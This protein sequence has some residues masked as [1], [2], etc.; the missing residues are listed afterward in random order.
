MNFVE[1]AVLEST[2]GVSFKK[3]VKVTKTEHDLTPA[4]SF[5]GSTKSLR[6]QLLEQ[7]EKKDEEWKKA[8]NPF[9]MPTA[10]AQFFFCRTGAP[11]ALNEDEVSFY[12]EKDDER[13]A[14]ELAKKNDESL[15]KSLFEQELLAARLQTV[16][17]AEPAPEAPAP[18]SKAKAEPRPVQMVVTT[19]TR[20]KD[21]SATQAGSK[22]EKK[23]SK[24][25]DAPESK[26]SSPKRA[27][28]SDG[29]S[30]SSKAHQP[31]KTGTQNAVAPAGTGALALLGQY[32]EDES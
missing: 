21:A 19:V 25:K 7:K 31:N 22:K 20:R 30:D 12:Q 29:K 3:E 11:A 15:A 1:S 5:T 14:K 9:R 24:R 17:A 18:A 28:T 6:D 32:D 13:R 4:R 26:A 8:N 16:K 27:K 10:L 23:G 2:D